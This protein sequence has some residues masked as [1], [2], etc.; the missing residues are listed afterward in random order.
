MSRR[1]TNLLRAKAVSLEGVF[2]AA[3]MRAERLRGERIAPLLGELRRKF[4]EVPPSKG[5]KE[6]AWITAYTKARH[7]WLLS[8]SRAAVKASAY[9]TKDLLKMIE[10][11]NW[12]LDKLP[13][14]ANGIEVR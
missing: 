1:A 7:E 10:E 2:S 12:N 13:L 9:R 6:K 3:S 11:K 5:G 4:P 8:R 14:I